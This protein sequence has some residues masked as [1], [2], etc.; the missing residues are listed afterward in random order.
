M[1]P[2]TLQVLAV[3]QGVPPDTDTPRDW[4]NA[5][6]TSTARLDPEQPQEVGRAGQQGHH[7]HRP[8]FC[9]C[10]LPA[11]GRVKMEKSPRM[12]QAA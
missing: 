1:G 4:C 11:E 6:Q 7:Y 12:S 8:G 2:F 10:P 3:R 5:Q 9:G